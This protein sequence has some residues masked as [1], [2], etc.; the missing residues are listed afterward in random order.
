MTHPVNI[1]QLAIHLES[2]AEQE[3]LVDMEK[4]SPE[5][6]SVQNRHDI[7]DK[8]PFEL[9]QTIFELLPI[10][11]VFAIKAASYS[12]HACPYASWKQRLE[13]AM[14]WLWEVR[15]M[16]PFKSQAMEA[17]FFKMFSELEKKSRYNKETVDYIPGLV[18]RRRIWG[19]CED[20]RSLYHDKLAEAQ[21]HQLDSTANLAVTRARF[22]AF[23]A[24]NP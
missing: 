9:R 15:D 3:L 21:G 14:P 16:N 10:A 6:T 4:S 13:T 17:K 11:S 1:P 18:N 12:M 23:K 19:I 8:L 20:I 7:F 5:S 2:I 24:E 22:A